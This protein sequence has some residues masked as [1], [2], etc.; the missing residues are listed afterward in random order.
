MPP[1]QLV[2]PSEDRE[3]CC[4][5]A[6]RGLAVPGRRR[7][8]VLQSVERGRFMEAQVA[9]RGFGIASSRSW[10]AM[11]GRMAWRRS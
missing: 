2:N 8:L 5:S 10:V 7:G 4:L 1:A 3:K 9:G 6:A 11:C